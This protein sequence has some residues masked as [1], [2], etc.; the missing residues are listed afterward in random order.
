MEHFDQL[1]RPA[2]GTGMRLP[3][4]FKTIGAASRGGISRA[5]VEI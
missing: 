1:E 4:S 5:A 2:A 3:I